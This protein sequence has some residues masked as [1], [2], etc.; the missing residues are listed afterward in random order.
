V[1]SQRTAGPHRGHTP[2]EGHG[3]HRT[4]AG[5][6][7]PAQQPPSTSIAGSPTTPVLPRTEELAGCRAA[8][9]LA[10]EARAAWTDLTPRPNWYRRYP[11][12]A[13]VVPTGRAIS[14]PF[15]ARRLRFITVSHGHS[16]P[17][18]LG[19]LY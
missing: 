3:Q 12:G 15:R 19:G 4:P 16:R 10:N 13:A 2:A 7:R 8:S 1:I 18:D 5:S 6:Q 11:A 9:P 14:V 17:F